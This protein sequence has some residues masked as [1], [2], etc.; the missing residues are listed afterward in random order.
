M[1]ITAQERT[2]IIKLTVAMFDA[3]PGATYLSFLTAAYE[4]NG[5]DMAGL[6]VQVADTGI[7]KSL[8]ADWQT[9]GQ[10]AAAFL[11]PLG[12]QANAVALNFINAKFAAGVS[13]GQ[14]I[15]EGI[16]ALNGTT[17]A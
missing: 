14:I 4:A 13:K 10:F 5:H 17:A 3:A 6:A 1:T 9:A 16:V 12:L 8:N 7:Y 2:D 15:Y 11:T